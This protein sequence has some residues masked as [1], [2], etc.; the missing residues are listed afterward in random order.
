MDVAQIQQNY[1]QIQQK[2]MEACKQSGRSIEEVTI[3]AVTKY[4]SMETTKNAIVA[5]I[6]NLGESRDVGFSN[7]YDTIT[8]QVT[9]HFIGSLQTRKVKNVINKIDYIHSLDRISL[10]KEINKR[11]TRQVKCFVQ[12]NASGEETKHGQKPENVINFIK[13]LQ[14]YPFIDVVGLMT[15]APYTDDK[16]VIRSVF[17]KLKELQKQVQALQ[18]PNASCKELSMGMSNDYEIAVQEG[19]TYLRI[20]TSLVGKE[21]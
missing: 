19:A 9:W 18:L 17:R 5:G 16:E 21:M 15:M 6:T 12:V 8:D 1:Q 20:G 14:E 11:S 4:V 13:E 7:K 2:V 10:A 3:I